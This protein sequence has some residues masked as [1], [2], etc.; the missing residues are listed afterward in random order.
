MADS[1]AVG[2]NK[3]ASLLRSDRSDSQRQQLEHPPGISSGSEWDSVARSVSDNGGLLHRTEGSADRIAALALAGA[4]VPALAAGTPHPAGMPSN[5]VRSVA[6]REMFGPAPR[7]SRTVVYMAK[8]A[9]DIAHST[10][11]RLIQRSQPEQL[12]VGQS[13]RTLKELPRPLF[14]ICVQC[15]AARRRLAGRLQ[16]CRQFLLGLQSPVVVVGQSNG[17]FHLVTSQPGV[18]LPILL[19]GGENR[20]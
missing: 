10:R 2:S 7:G 18:R 11:C 6:A 4:I 1:P 16:Q 19:G 13:E 15:I 14:R 9:M 3:K 5:S 20:G 12:G 8:A 17:A